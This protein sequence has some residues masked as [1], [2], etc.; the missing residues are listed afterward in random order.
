MVYFDIL[1]QRE[2]VEQERHDATALRAFFETSC[3]RFL[4]WA[5]REIAHRQ[6]RD[7]GLVALTFPHGDFR[8][9][10][11]VLA[12]SVYK[13][14]VA[15]RTLLAQAPTGIGKSIGTVFPAL[16][17]MPGQRLDKLFFLSA[18]TTGR[19]VALQAAAQLRGGGDE[20]PLRV[21]ELTARDKAC[22][23]PD[24]ACHGESCPLAQGF[25]DRLPA[26][27]KPPPPCRCSTGTPCAASP[28]S[29][30]SAPTTLPRR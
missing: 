8:P 1:S 11:R 15:A 28:A 29:T 4:Q 16:K 30:T 24:L 10:Q 20:A 25:Y 2:R 18:R 7:A 12:E 21:L 23:H 19:A 26:A 14:N 13:A 27:R 6:A 17:S 3:R 5:E 9:G 22:E